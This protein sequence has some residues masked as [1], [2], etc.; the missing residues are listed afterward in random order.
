MHLLKSITWSLKCYKQYVMYARLTSQVHMYKCIH[1]HTF[2][3]RCSN[4][5]LTLDKIYCKYR[6]NYIYTG[7]FNTSKS[8]SKLCSKYFVCLLRTKLHTGE[9]HYYYI[10][11]YNYTKGLKLNSHE[12]WQKL[13][14]WT[15][16]LIK[17][18]DSYLSQLSMISQYHS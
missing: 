4:F 15:H 5:G 9:V 11:V 18:I 10:T 7:L 17:L 8:I 13:Q 2:I 14:R 16:M 6:L 3:P 12:N 1:V